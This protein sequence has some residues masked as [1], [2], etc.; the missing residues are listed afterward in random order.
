MH[1]AKGASLIEKLNGVDEKNASSN[2]SSERVKKG[3]FGRTARG[4]GFSK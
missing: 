4:A 3:E 1:Q 2:P